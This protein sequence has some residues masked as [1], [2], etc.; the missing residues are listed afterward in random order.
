M[1]LRI[2]HILSFLLFCSFL[3]SGTDGSIKG[4][5]LDEGGNPVPFANVV[6]GDIDLGIGAPADV[7]GEF[8]IINVPVG[9]YDISVQAMGF[10]PYKIEG[11]SVRMDETSKVNAILVEESIQAGEVVVSAEKELVEKGAT[12]KK[13]TI[14]KET[15]EAL[16]IK[17]MSSLFDLQAGVVKVEPGTAGGESGRSERGLEEVHVRGGRTGEIAYMIDGMYIRNPIYGGI[18]SGTRLNLF[19][20]KEWDWQPGGFDAEY[21]DAMSAVS[22]YHTMRGTKNFTTKLKYESSMVG[23]MLGNEYDKLRGYDDYNWGFG[24]KLPLPD[25]LG[26]LYF[27]FSGQTT[28]NANYRVYEFDDL[29]YQDGDIGNMENRENLVVPWDNVV[30][31]RGFGFNNTSDMLANISWN[32]LNNKLRLNLSYWTVE[33]HMKPF[34]YSGTFLYWDEGQNEI[35]RDTERWSFDINH[36]LGQKTFYTIR[37]ARFTQDLFQG[38]R[39]RDSD[40]DGRPDWFEN[41]HGAGE[42][43]NSTG[44]LMSDPYNEYVVPYQF[45]GAGQDT[46]R[47]ILR[48]GAGPDEFNS[49]WFV[50]ADDPGNYNWEVS[51]EFIDSNY[52]ELYDD[53]EEF[54][55]LNNNGQW[56]GP[57]LTEKCIFRDGSYWL[58]PE[59][60]VNFA[61]FY[62]DQN[63]WLD[64]EMDPA[65]ASGYAAY[66]YSDSLYF[67]PYGSWVEGRTFGGTDNIYG[68]STAV[69]DEVR[70]D[71][72]RQMTDEWKARIG[73]D[74]KSH[75]LNFY[76]VQ[77]PWNGLAA[78]KQ[79]FAEQWDDYGVDGVYFLDS[80]TGQPDEGEGNGIWD[81]G[82]SFDDFNGDNTWN[83]Y[84]EPVELSAYFKNTFE[85]D[86]MVV[87][88][89]LR[90]DAVNYQTQL[91]ADP[92]GEYSPEKPWFWS[93]CG[94]DG[95][96]SDSNYWTQFEIDYAPDEGENDGIYQ[97]GGNGVWNYGENFDDCSEDSPNICEGNPLFVEGSGNGSWDEGENFEDLGEPT[98]DQFGLSNP[99]VFFEKSKWQ[100]KISPRLGFSHVITDKATFT[101]NYG[102]YYQTPVYENIYLNTNRQS[103][104]EELFEESA[105]FI[106]NASMT[107]ARTQA[108]EFAFNVQIGNNWGLTMGAWVKDMDQLSTYRFQRSG[109]FEYM[110]ASSGDFGR[111]S[112]IDITLQNRGQ[113]VNTMVQ[114]T[115][116]KAK[117]NGAYAQS[118][119]GGQYVDAPQQEYTMPFDRPH[120]LSVT[121]YSMLPFGINASL[122][123]MYQSGFPYTPMIFSGDKPQADEKNRYTERSEAY[124]MVNM[125][126]SKYLRLGGNKFHMGL[127][128]FN[129][130][131]LKNDINIYPLTGN[132]DDPGDY[133][134]QDIALPEDGG[135][136]SSAFYDRPWYYSSAREINFF[137]QV[138][139]GK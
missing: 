36:S 87:N 18:G 13:V 99:L 128:I 110:V 95:L 63:I 113:L 76:E 88:A 6:I 72:T 100:Y 26:G 69:T 68:T 35:F 118:A 129:I 70:F 32:L 9:I 116:S 33:N 51:E 42:S 53:G 56:D 137:V 14:G 126:F 74:L 103:E 98:S 60:Y 112:G 66:Q 4:K 61:N 1:R 16:P 134:T 7:E 38:V 131:D 67:L 102:I 132:A 104:P 90:I 136:I 78:F 108:Y 22:N 55:D 135:T 122:T 34:D 49:G 15:I 86:W 77:N 138:E 24:G 12:S 27:W 59:M 79:R 119:F 47:Y 109:V 117:A 50:G 28:T 71:I 115:Y 81:E 54:V 25:V 127:N 96:C 111:A 31:F 64:Y 114:Y 89:G 83:D 133:Y 91:W 40:D 20:I 85:K 19:A 94:L 45:S 75:K 97:S 124:K 92:S 43:S 58:T 73:I 123:G 106:G 101:F 8:H 21:G 2:I 107:S 120:D 57:E 37:L 10:A 29:V 44:Q 82:E 130:L 84:V 62:D 41:R 23:S 39:W 5:V 11:V 48:D 121:L 105:G 46:I 139:I 17:D 125:S 30:G 52:N 65:I 3:F 80:E 93:D